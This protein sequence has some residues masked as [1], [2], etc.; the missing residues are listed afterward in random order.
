[1]L[2]KKGDAMNLMLKKREYASPQNVFS[3]YRK[4]SEFHFVII[5]RTVPQLLKFI[6]MRLKKAKD[7]QG[8]HS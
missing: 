1:L 3:H 6:K 8:N 5:E 4:I 7:W 2:I